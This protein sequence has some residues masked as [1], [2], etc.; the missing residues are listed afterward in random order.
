MIFASVE[1]CAVACTVKVWNLGWA[2]FGFQ[3]RII[4][5]NIYVWIRRRGLSTEI[6]AICILGS[7]V[8]FRI[9]CALIL[10]HACRCV[11]L[12][13]REIVRFLVPY[14]CVSIHDSNDQNSSTTKLYWIDTATVDSLPN[15]VRIS[16]VDYEET[17][18]CN[19][20]GRTCS[21]RYSNAWTSDIN[22]CNNVS[23][24]ILQSG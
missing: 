6:R 3:N 20:S 22:A 10:L 11:N 2:M 15:V 12:T 23:R 14:T 5:W 24:C 8:S 19:L 16:R 21:C 9:E 18:N 1:T 13:G 17:R 7:L 4:S